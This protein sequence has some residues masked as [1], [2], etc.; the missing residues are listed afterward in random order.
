Q[1]EQQRRHQRQRLEAGVALRGG[2]MMMRFRPARRGGRDRRRQLLAAAVAPA[3]G[4]L[5]RGQ[6][7][8][9]VGAGG[10]DHGSLPARR[11]WRGW[12]LTR[13]PAPLPYY[14]DRGGRSE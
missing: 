2:G 10:R 5:A 12:G 3:V 13:R 14:D 8:V 7:G 1:K 6:P 9:A 11:S 4:Q